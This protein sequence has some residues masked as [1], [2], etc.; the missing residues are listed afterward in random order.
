MFNLFGKKKGSEPAVKTIS[1]ATAVSGKF[2]ALEEVPDPVFSGK[3]VGEG[4]AVEPENGIIAAPVSGELTSLF[5]TKHAFGIKTSEGLEVLVHVGIDTV[6]LKGEGFTA[7]AQIGEV[8][9]VGQKIL[10]VD[11]A[12]LKEAGKSTITPV[13]VTNMTEVKQMEVVKNLSNLEADTVVLA[14]TMN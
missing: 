2:I 3:M 11:L 8:V 6:Q 1:V 9:Q 7:F 12:V 13:I 10:E 5:P 14:V 4:F